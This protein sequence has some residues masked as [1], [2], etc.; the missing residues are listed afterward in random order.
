MVGGGVYRG[1]YLG[2]IWEGYTGYLHIPS[3]DPY[4]I[5]FS[6]KGPTHGPKN[7]IFSK[8]MRFPEVS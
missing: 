4:F 6:L 2:G 5:I 8:M 1:G 3:Q 7:L